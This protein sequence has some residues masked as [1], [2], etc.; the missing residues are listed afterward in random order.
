MWT[1]FY[2]RII[3]TLKDLNI[4]SFGSQLKT[5]LFKLA[6]PPHSH[7]LLEGACWVMTLLLSVFLD[8]CTL[9]D[10][11]QVCTIQMLLLLLNHS[12]I[13]SVIYIYNLYL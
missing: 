5:Y 3:S 7:P 8:S 1:L 6:Y 9:K 10:V 11:H 13:V 4:S 2:A 12:I